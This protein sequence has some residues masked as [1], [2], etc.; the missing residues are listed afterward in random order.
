MSVA[1]LYNQFG[2]QGLR[3]GPDLKTKNC[4]QLLWC[5]L[6]V[7]KDLQKKKKKKGHRFQNSF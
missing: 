6:H 3:I 7:M 5:E 2:E 1:Q 4:A